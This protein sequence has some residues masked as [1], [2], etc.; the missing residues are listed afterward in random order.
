MIALDPVNRDI[1][2]PH[3]INGLGREAVIRAFRFL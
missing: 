2:E 1:L 3:F